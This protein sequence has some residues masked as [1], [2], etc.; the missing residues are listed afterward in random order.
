MTVAIPM[1]MDALG[2]EFVVVVVIHNHNRAKVY[3][4]SMAFQ[5]L[6][7]SAVK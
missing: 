4:L 7:Y 6:F 5:A 2:R 3:R 1:N